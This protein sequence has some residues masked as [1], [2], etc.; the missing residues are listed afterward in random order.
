MMFDFHVFSHFASNKPL[1]RFGEINKMNF[2]NSFIRLHY[3]FV[4]PTHV[5]RRR[6]VIFVIACDGKSWLLHLWFTQ[7]WLYLDYYGAICRYIWIHTYTWYV[8]ENQENWHKLKFA[9]N[10]AYISR[11]QSHCKTTGRS[12]ILCKNDV[13]AT[14][15]SQAGDDIVMVLAPPS[16]LLGDS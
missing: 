6:M 16:S 8:L 1:S 10:I 2:W 11:R 15:V 9:Q 7:P 5:S 3:L 14:C 4:W 13:I 12:C